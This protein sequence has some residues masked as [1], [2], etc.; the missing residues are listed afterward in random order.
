M[1]RQ[2][3]RA[4]EISVNDDDRF[5]LWFYDGAEEIARVP[6]PLQLA[7]DVD[8]LAARRVEL[9][10]VLAERG[11]TRMRVLPRTRSRPKEPFFGLGHLL[12][13]EAI[14]ATPTPAPIRH[15]KQGRRPADADESDTDDMEEGA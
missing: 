15:G 13:D 10:A 14:D 1:V 9:P 6:V 3:H 12:F 11:F 5:E 8:G 2:H 7:W 4:L